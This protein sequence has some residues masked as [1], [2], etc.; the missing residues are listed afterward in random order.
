[1]AT[2]AQHYLEQQLKERHLGLMQLR[3][4]EV[5]GDLAQERAI[6]AA[7]AEIERL[8][9][10]L[11]RASVRVNEAVARRKAAERVNRRGRNQ[12]DNRLGPVDEAGPSEP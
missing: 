10:E 12:G 7:T 5:S 11:R 8:H 1:M 6:E 4:R 2:D 9:E 3:N